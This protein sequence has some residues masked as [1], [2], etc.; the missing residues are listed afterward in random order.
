[1]RD[2]VLL[3][4]VGTFLDKKNKMTYPA[5]KNN[6]PDLSEGVAVHLKECSDE[7]YEALSA[8]DKKII[9]SIIVDWII[10]G[11]IDEK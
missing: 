8:Y 4:S 1:M 9:A 11:M 3:K 10:P 6:T 7:W 5:Y 2:L